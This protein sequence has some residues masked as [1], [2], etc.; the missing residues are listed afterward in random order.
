MKEEVKKGQLR[1]KLSQ[2]V[3][4]KGYAIWDKNVTWKNKANKSKSKPNTV[5]DN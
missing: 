4:I 1:E 2:Q 3:F 5:T